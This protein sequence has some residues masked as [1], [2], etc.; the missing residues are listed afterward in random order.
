MS[1]SSDHSVRQPD[2]TRRK[3]LDAAFAE[4]FRNGFQGGSL[5]RIVAGA[6]VTKGALFHHFAGK[7]ELGYAVVD[8]VIEPL[9]MQRWLGGLEGAADPVAAM[10]DAFRRWSRE[11]VESG[12]WLNGC[13][14]NNVAQEMSPLDEGFRARVDALYAAW[15]A[16]F[17]AALARGMEAGTVRGDA[18]PEGA[19]ALL[20]AAQMGVWGTGKASRDADLMLEA[21]EAACDYLE[22]LRPAA[23]PAAGGTAITT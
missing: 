13:P 23:P 16:A 15:R 8:E 12:G 11:D 5:A 14:L 4:F 9:L 19:A 6:G 21:C 10:Q 18:S 20:V 7:Q 3:I 2:V 17:A 1:M 22:R